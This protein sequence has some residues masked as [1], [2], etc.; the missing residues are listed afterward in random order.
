[1][2][3]RYRSAEVNTLVIWQPA[4]TGI[5]FLLRCKMRN[6]AAKAV[7]AGIGLALGF[8]MGCALYFVGTV[9][10][11]PA[12]TRAHPSCDGF[13]LVFEGAARLGADELVAADSGRD[14]EN[15]LSNEDEAIRAIEAGAKPAGLTP[16]VEI[17]RARLAIRRAIRAERNHDAVVQAES[18]GQAARL[19]QSAA[20]HD[21]SAAHL[22]A[23]IVLSDQQGRRARTPGGE[24]K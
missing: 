22:R 24:T 10:N 19:L 13:S 6:W 14:D 4:G 12:L 5:D 9:S 11:N 7:C 3:G 2:A 18:D 16:P 8:A 20:W 23:L 1:M 17:A 21:T 15:L